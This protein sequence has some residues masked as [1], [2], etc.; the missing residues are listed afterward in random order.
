MP[1]A[2]SPTG[3]TWPGNAAQVPKAVFQRDDIY[4][5]EMARIFGGPEWHLIAHRA[6]VPESGDFK[7]VQVGEASVLLVHGD[8]G[9]LRVFENSC[10]HRGTQLKTCSQGNG[11][12]IECPYHRW[13]FD[14][15][16]ELLN[17]PGVE[18]FPDSFAKEDYGLVSLRL[19][20]HCGLIFVTR[21]DAAPPL[22]DYLGE[23]GG[24]LIKAMQGDGRLK[25]LGYQKV[26]FATNWKEYNDQEGYHAPLLHSAFRLL[27]W[28][29]GK[30]SRCVSAY[31]HLSVEA[32]LKQ[33]GNT[34]FL[35]DP[36]LVLTH[37]Q[38]RA[39]RTDTRPRML[40]FLPG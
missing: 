36:S 16:G 9:T 37:D 12:E 32:D 11:R 21:Q 13:R 40:D 23:A 38:T 7:A 15:R 22:E 8:D 27:G 17:A 25:L 3:F 34:D 39:P 19:A 28:L 6:E 35:K 33:I 31:G 4:A 30:G 18:H 24:F 5:E 14:I 29:G 10:P 20:E 26:A 1:D 2:V